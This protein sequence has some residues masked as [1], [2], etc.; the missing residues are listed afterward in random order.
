MRWC[1]YACVCACASN[2][3]LS[4]TGGAKFEDYADID[5]APEGTSLRPEDRCSDWRFLV[6]VLSLP[7]A[8]H[9]SNR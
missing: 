7:T 2:A 1:S 6:E 4:K 8:V 3:V 9:H 5:K